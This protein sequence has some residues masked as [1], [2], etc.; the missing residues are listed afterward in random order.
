MANDDLFQRQKKILVP[1]LDRAQEIE[2]IAPKVS[3]YCRLFA[4]EEAVK[5]GENN[6]DPRVK[7]VIEA[8]ADKLADSA[9][10]LDLDRQRDAVECDKFAKMVF[11]RADKMERID[12]SDKSLLSAAQTFKYAEQY[13][14][15]TMQFGSLSEES[16]R[17]RKYA[18]WRSLELLKAHKEMR[19][20]VAPPEISTDAAAMAELEALI[21]GP[22]ENEDGIPGEFTFMSRN[23]KIMH[24]D[25][26]VR[27]DLII[28]IVPQ[29]LQVQ[30][31]GTLIHRSQHPLLKMTYLRS[32]S[33]G[34]NDKPG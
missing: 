30:C 27:F 8:V 33:I 4:L 3:Y 21:S 16:E 24:I 11:A 26:V 31:L 18:L 2:A 6:L 19:P 34:T 25:H 23:R 7:G 22:R 10:T 29:T 17:L 13:F 12:Q 1:F 15:M 20:P 5:L 28:R 9:P 32:L 14:R